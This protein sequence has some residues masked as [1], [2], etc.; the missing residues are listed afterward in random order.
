[1]NDLFFHDLE[2]IKR[3][4]KQYEAFRSQ[5][6]SVVIAGPGSGKTRV[7]TLKAVALVG[8]EIKN[9]FG[10]AC[11]SFSRETVRELRKRLKLYGFVGRKN[12]FIGTV[13]S[14]S[15]LHVLQPFGH[16]FP[17]YG[18][19]YP[20][21]ILPDEERDGIHRAIL[22][23][24]GFEN[25]HDMSMVDINKYR[26]LA[27]KGR[28]RVEIESHRS[29]AEAAKLFEQKLSRTDYIDFTGIINVAA[30]IIHEQE[31]VRHALQCKFPWLLVDEYQDL[32]KALHEMVLELVFNASINLYAVGDANQSIYGF[33]GGYPEFLNELA[34][35]DNIK[36]IFL[37]ANYRSSQHIIDASIEALNPSP[38]IPSYT[39]QNVK[40][41]A[42]DFSFITCEEEI[43]E[44]FDLIAR[45]IIPKMMGRDTVL[46]E[47]GIIVNSNSEVRNM[48]RALK[49]SNIPFFIA[50]WQF[51]NSA[52]VVWLQECANWCV[53]RGSQNFDELVK[54]WMSLLSNHND[55]RKNWP[56]I[57]IRMQL[58]N[59]LSDSRNPD[60][61]FTW[62][63]QVINNLK[64]MELLSDSELYPDEPANLQLLL[65]EASLQNLKGL[66]LPRF[67]K[68][69]TPEN[70]V[71]ITTR[72]SSKGLEFEVVILPGMEEGHFPNYYHLDNPVALAEDQRL[73]YVCISRA[74]RT[75]ILLRSC[76]FTI[77]TKNG[78]WRKGF[79]PSRYW[80]S[81]YQRFG[82]KENTFTCDMV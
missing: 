77:T 8:T 20:I 56:K 19:K 80:E 79:K 30:Q 45:K 9:P 14:F 81:L 68:L 10:L 52:V 31:F 44:Q 57:Q 28:S 24:L 33:N 16:L 72:H 27:I 43:A 39:A 21:K 46:N 58:F 82:T 35:N 47:I 23:E 62:L 65:D 51:E 4:E 18:I 78:P 41:V 29:F 67:A 12:D 13:H 6:S 37:N 42:P 7:L 69:G 26:S 32:G 38:P 3:D 36:T 60:T 22:K 40:N 11:I 50:N 54:F 59:T 76:F 49:N 74:K 25:K 17:Q 70:E 55:S 71:T 5:T 53:D 2:L 15:L 64:L 34:K 75:C 66:Q 61:I 48:A 1:M 73:C 63:S